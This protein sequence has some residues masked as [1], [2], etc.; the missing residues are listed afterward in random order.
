MLIRSTDDRRHESDR[1]K[2]DAT[3]YKGPER[4]TGSNRRA[5]SD[6]RQFP[7]MEFIQG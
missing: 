2:G 6:R 7:R 3:N 1:R 5:G 4:R